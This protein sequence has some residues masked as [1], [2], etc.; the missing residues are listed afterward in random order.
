MAKQVELAISPRDVSGK[1][2]KRLR[3]EG[4][5]P[6]NIFGHGEESQAV[7]LTALDFDIAEE[8]VHPTA[9]NTE[10]L[11]ILCNMQSAFN[12]RLSHLESKLAPNSS[13]TNTRWGMNR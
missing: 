4:V 1:A 7:Q 13:H 2:T 6:A 12:Q 3:R 8:P 11:K 5:V 10:V 9:M